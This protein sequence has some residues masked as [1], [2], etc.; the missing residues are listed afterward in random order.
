ML[1]QASGRIHHNHHHRWATWPLC[2]KDKGRDRD[3]ASKG[4][5]MEDKSVEIEGKVRDIEDKVKVVVG[6]VEGEVG[7][8]VEPTRGDIEACEL[9]AII[10]Q[11]SCRDEY[12]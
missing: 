4:Q 1:R 8:E 12:V 10:L 7:G 9:I 2:Y 11:G 6:K 5:D 3:R